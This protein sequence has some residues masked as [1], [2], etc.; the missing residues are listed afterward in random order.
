MKEVERPTYF[1][2][3]KLQMDA[4]LWGEEYSKLE[5]PKKVCVS[6]PFQIFLRCIALG[7]LLPDVHHRVQRSRREPPLWGGALHRW[8]LHQVQLQLGVC[9]R[10]EP[11]HPT[12]LQPFHLREV[13]SPADSSG[14]SRFKNAIISLK[15]SFCPLIG[16]GD[17][18]TDPQIH[19]ID[20]KDYGEANL[21][22]RGMALFF[23]SHV[24]SPLC[25]M[26]GMF[27]TFLRDLWVTCDPYA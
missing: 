16:V 6:F 12:D 13:E 9:V 8:R 27:V 11:T 17:L 14:H 4:K 1:D 5:I 18:Y 24:C 10:R 7:G 26:L 25:E 3:V 2:D 20:M 19:T 15:L 21:G 23:S 22:T